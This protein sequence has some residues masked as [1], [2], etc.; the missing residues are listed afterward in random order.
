MYLVRGSENK[1]FSVDAKGG[2][3]KNPKSLEEAKRLGS[4]VARTLIKR[5]EKVKK[6]RR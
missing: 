5:K 4:L 6:Q 1:V 3:E 2:V